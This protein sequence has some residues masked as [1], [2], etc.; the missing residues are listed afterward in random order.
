MDKHNEDEDLKQEA[1][2]LSLQVK[3]D[4]DAD[5]KKALW[6]SHSHTNSSGS[7]ENSQHS[8][9]HNMPPLMRASPSS[10]TVRGSHGLKMSVAANNKQK[11][12]L[13]MLRKE[14]QSRFYN[15]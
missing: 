10:S 2:R 12:D 9:N 7:G 3:R 6:L 8:Q 11:E 15:R 13:E 4:E 14:L 5:L 1:L